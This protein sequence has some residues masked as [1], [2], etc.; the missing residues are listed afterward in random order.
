LLVLVPLGTI[1][2]QFGATNAAIGYGQII[3][4]GIYVA[5]PFITFLLD[6]LLAG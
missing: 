5:V 4:L 2:A 1:R 6:R 3:L